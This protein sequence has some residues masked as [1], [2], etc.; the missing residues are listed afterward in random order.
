MKTNLLAP[1]ILAFFAATTSLAYAE[2]VVVVPDDVDT[3]V[4]EQPYD[5]A[6]TVHEDIIVGQPLPE[7]VVIRPVPRYDDYGYA[8][9]NER[10]VI[11]E[12]RTRR[13]IR[14]YD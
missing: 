1:C 5:D 13:I 7:T 8:V 2:D 11:V 10:R 4:Q 14:V 3:Y 12:P 6:V 9:V